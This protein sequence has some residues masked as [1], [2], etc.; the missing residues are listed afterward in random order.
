MC[1][2]SASDDIV[3]ML[4]AMPPK[5]KGKKKATNPGLIS[6]RPRGRRSETYDEDLADEEDGAEQLLERPSS[7]EGIEAG[8]EA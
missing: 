4:Q 5:A 1:A 8:A 3:T 7:A 2:H 6:S